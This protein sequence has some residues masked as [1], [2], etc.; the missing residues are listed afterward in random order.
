MSE[1]R[2]RG[3]EEE[4]RI[5]ICQLRPQLYKLL[6]IGAGACQC[7]L[8]PQLNIWLGSIYMT[9][10]F[11]YNNQR[12]NPKNRFLAT[13]WACVTYHEGSGIGLSKAQLKRRLVKENFASSIR[14]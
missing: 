4:R 7:P 2:R 11:H 10:L 1:E 13:L 3:G 9:F 8:Q 5:P 12:V 14:L 6:R